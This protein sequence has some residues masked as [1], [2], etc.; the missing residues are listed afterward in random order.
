MVTGAMR[1]GW[2]HPRV[3]KEKRNED[4]SLGDFRYLRDKQRKRMS[5]RGG[6]TKRV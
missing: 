4:R 5:K 1:G 2:N 6:K 3:Y